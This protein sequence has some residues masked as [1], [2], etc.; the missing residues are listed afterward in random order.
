VR[1]LSGMF[2]VKTEIFPLPPLSHSLVD[3]CTTSA[4]CQRYLCSKERRGEERGWLTALH[5]A[6]RQE[7]LSACKLL[8]GP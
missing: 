4:G 1:A 8:F 3:F 2:Q 6:W 5:V 7:L